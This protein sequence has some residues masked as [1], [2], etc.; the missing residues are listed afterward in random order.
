MWIA[1]LVISGIILLCRLPVIIFL[2]FNPSKISYGT[3]LFDKNRERLFLNDIL[4]WDTGAS[5]SMLYEGCEDK[6]EYKKIPFSYVPVTD[7]FGKVR[8]QKLCYSSQ[9]NLIDSLIFCKFCFLLLDKPIEELKYYNENEI[10]MTGMDVIGKANWLIDFTL[11]KIEISPKANTYK[12]EEQAQLILKY[13]KID[14][15]PKTHLDFSVCQLENVLIDAGSSGELTL[16]KSD[17]E[18]INNKYKPTDT[19]T[20][21]SYGLY[22]TSPVVQHCYVYDTIKI[23]NLYCYNVQ[24]V[25]GEKRAIGFKFFKRFNKVY[26]STKE[27]E[28]R[29][30]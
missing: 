11:G 24:I 18:Q 5:E 15:R 1:A 20:A 17:I 29:F 4:L 21:T 7:T 30:Y 8:F 25:E 2:N 26:L 23:N 10:G 9:F 6:I 14:R 19:L 12:P 22:S 16:L 3:F 13:K 27:E 28:F